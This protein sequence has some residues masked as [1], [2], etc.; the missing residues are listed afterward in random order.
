MHEAAAENTNGNASRQQ[1]GVPSKEEIGWMFV[2]Q[3]YT[4]LYENPGNMHVS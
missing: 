1:P 4:L 3:Y 2:Q